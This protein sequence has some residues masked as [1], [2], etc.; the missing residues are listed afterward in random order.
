[1]VQVADVAREADVLALRDAVL[2]RAGRIDVL[3]NNAGVNPIFRGIERISL[4]DWQQHHRRQPD[5]R[6]PV[7]QAYRRRD[8]A[9][10]GSIINVSSVAGHVRAAALGAVLRVEGRR[11]DADQARWRWTGRSAACG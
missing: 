11:G 9:G 2:A 1:M 4:E 7:L 3:V 5:R 6:V 10:R 8:G